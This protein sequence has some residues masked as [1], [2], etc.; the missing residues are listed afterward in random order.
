MKRTPATARKAGTAI[1][2]LADRLWRKVITNPA[3][4]CWEW[5]GYRMKEGYGQIG[6][7]GRADGIILTHRAAYQ[8]VNGPIPD[9]L[10]IRHKCDNPPCCNPDHLELGTPA[11]NVA[12][13]VNRGRIP[14]G[15][16]LPQTILTPEDVRTIRREWKAGTTTVALAATYGVNR[17]YI[18]A[19]ARRKE[20]ADVQD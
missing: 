11:D 13:T 3:T 7:G 1:T 20:R 19:V 10:F 4:G 14:R 9:G 2:P 16:L 8:I 15:A 17:R 5:Q 12:D 18:L 6:V